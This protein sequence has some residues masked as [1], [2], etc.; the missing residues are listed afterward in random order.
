MIPVVDAATLF[1]AGVL[2]DVIAALYYVAVAKERIVLAA[3]ISFALTEFSYLSYFYVLSGT[4]LEQNIDKIHW[5]AAGCAAGTFVGLAI[6]LRRRKKV[7][8]PSP[9][10][11]A[12]PSDASVQE[13]ELVA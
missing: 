5:Y 1:A 9:A 11:E 3:V 7:E 8:P 12:E 13:P 4:K 2:L 10:S 6:G